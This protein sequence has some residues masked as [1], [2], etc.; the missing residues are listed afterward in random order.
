[1][2]QK[3]Y[4]LGI[5][6]ALIIF[7]GVIFKVNH[8]P[9]AGY[10]LI[11]GIAA[12]ILAFLPLSLRNHYKAEGNKQNLLLHVATWLT[13][14]VV[15]TGML[16]KIMHWPGGGIAMSISIP[17]PYIVFLPVFLVTTAKNKNFNIYNTVFVLLLLAAISVFSALLALNV[18]AERLRDSYNLSTHYIKVE[19]VLNQLPARNSQSTV[20]VK[21]DE[22]LK[23]VYEYKE[24]I[25][26]REGTSAE[27]W[28]NAEGNVLVR[29]DSPDAAIIA[30]SLASNEIVGEKLDNSLKA[31]V[32][33][34]EN[35]PGCED[36]AKAIPSIF[37]L[38]LQYDDDP[39]R[40][41]HNL[42][43]TLSWTLI[44]LDGVETNLK[45]IKTVVSPND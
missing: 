33:E 18:S 31:L 10:M 43:N 26:K 1:M 25:L 22:A 38:R 42:T 24:S 9:G 17:F 13:C 14:F 32:K 23:I 27:Q 5:V 21:I 39:N 20:C 29:H 41:F 40:V 8:W 2:K 34:I 6:T 3:I 28:E 4:I 35:T 16:F 45:L 12:F 44:Y 37:D 19:K 7:L 36:L 30:L 15:F 11:L